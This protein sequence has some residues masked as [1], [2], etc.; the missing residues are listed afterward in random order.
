MHDENT[1]KTLQT[2]EAPGTYDFL[3]VTVDEVLQWQD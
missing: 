3:K 1:D 2:R